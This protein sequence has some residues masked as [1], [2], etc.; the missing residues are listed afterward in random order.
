MEDQI[1]VETSLFDDPG[2]LRL[3]ASDQVAQRAYRKLDFSFVLHICKVNILDRPWA[4]TDDLLSL[5]LSLK[6]SHAI[7]Y[8]S[9]TLAVDEAAASTTAIRGF[10]LG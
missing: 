6:L 8:E 2:L 9:S 3:A 7:L 10:H 1:V 4:H 5:V